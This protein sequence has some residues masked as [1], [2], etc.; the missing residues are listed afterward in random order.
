MTLTNRTS[1]HRFAIA[2]KSWLVGGAADEARSA[3]QY[4]Y[5]DGEMRPCPGPYALLAGIARR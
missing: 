1:F 3:S 4:N 5:R 2:V